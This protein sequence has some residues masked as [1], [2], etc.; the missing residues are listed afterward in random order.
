[1]KLAKKLL[2]LVQCEPYNVTSKDGEVA[3]THEYSVDKKGNGQTT[4]TV[5]D[6]PDHIHD[7]KN[8]KVKKAGKD[9]H[10][11]TIKQE[12]MNDDLK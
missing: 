9:G 4:F 8:W 5:G 10:T 2:E 3:H 12:N 1:M 7:I 6:A 11:H